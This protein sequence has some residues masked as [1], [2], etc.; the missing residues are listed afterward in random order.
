MEAQENRGKALEQLILHQRTALY[1]WLW[2]NYDQFSPIIS[3]GVG[4]RGV[5][6]GLQKMAKD[7]VGISTSPQNLR[8][9][10]LRVHRNKQARP[11]SQ[12]AERQRGILP[13]ETI[14][15][16]PSAFDPSRT[17]VPPKPRED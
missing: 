17:V 6:V 16:R 7:E 4:K 2:V 10:W 3:A 8:Q 15:R 11:Q 5:F 9:T 1:Q 12:R 13:Q 14:P